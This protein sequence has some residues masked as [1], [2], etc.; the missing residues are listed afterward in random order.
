MLSEQDKKYSFKYNLVGT[1]Y[2]HHAVSTFQA[3]M[4]VT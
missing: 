3:N 2:L 1:K 4:E